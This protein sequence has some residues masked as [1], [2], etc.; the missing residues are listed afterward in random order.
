MINNNYNSSKSLF[1]SSKFQ[2]AREIV[3]LKLIDN[4][5]T[6]PQQSFSSPGLDHMSPNRGPPGYIKRAAATFVNCVYS[7]ITKFHN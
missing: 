1:C 3:F 4:L 7:Y 6:R 2:L 5:A